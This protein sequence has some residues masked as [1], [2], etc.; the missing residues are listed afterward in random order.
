MEKDSR[1]FVAGGSTLIGAAILRALDRDGCRNVVGRDSLEPDLRDSTAVRDFFERFAP[2]YV[3]LAAGKTGGIGA[4]QRY[5][6][7]LM[8]DNLLVECHV[9]HEAYRHNVKKLLCLASSCT[10][11]RLA[12][13][14]LSEDSL[15]TGSLEPT[16]EAYAVAKIAGMILCR[17]YCAQYGVSFLS[18]VPANAF[19]PGDDLSLED[20]HVIPALLRRMH[21]AKVNGLESVEIWGT[22][23]ATREFIYADD[24]AEG[25]L[26]VMRTYDN[27]APINISGGDPISIRA[28]ASLIKEVVGYAGQVRFD[29]AKPDGMPFKALDGSRIRALGWRPRTALRAAIASTYEWVA[30]TLG[31][32]PTA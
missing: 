32:N 3:F 27:P 23:A 16:N 13:Q 14:P 11:P 12:P 17:A 30:S 4:N 15:M 1:I 24:L 21:E 25:C 26:F 2:E 5:P 9:I 19:G 28:L 20:S 10:Y 7:E 22:G 29:T 31:N 6:A 8:L 18:A